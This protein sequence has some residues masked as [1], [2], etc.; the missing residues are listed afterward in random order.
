METKHTGEAKIFK[1]AKA[2][3]LVAAFRAAY[4]AANRKARCP[5]VGIAQGQYYELIKQLI[6]E[7]D[8]SIR[9]LRDGR[10][11]WKGGVV[12]IPFLVTE[13]AAMALPEYSSLM[14]INDHGEIVYGI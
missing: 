9:I 10:V 13:R 6:A 3:N 11:I 12:L 14:F 8:D 7:D 4:L 2:P 1:I 5:I